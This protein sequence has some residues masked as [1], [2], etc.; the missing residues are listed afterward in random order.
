MYLDGTKGVFRHSS[1]YC[2]LISPVKPL[3]DRSNTPRSSAREISLGRN[4]TNKRWLYNKTTLD[5]ITPKLSLVDIKR[6][7]LLSKI[8]R[9]EDKTYSRR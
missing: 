3:I 7:K 1:I 6:G 4:S 8:T 5:A 2:E 9:K